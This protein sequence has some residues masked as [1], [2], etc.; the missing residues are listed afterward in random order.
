MKLTEISVFCASC[1]LKESYSDCKYIGV[2]GKMLHL[3]KTT[4]MS[5]TRE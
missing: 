2:T 5:D 1:V 3:L 4:C